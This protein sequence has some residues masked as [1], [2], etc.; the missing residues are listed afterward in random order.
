MIRDPQD[1]AYGP[2]VP[3]AASFGTVT[4]RNLYANTAGDYLMVVPEAFMAAAQPLPGV[5]R[6]ESGGGGATRLVRTV[7]ACLPCDPRRLQSGQA[8]A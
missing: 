4:R 6:Q 1:P 7:G 3:P 8:V 5:G 2:R